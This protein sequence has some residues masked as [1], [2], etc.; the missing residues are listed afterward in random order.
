[1]TRNRTETDLR[2]IAL[3][4]K[5]PE[6]ILTPIKTP[7]ALPKAIV[8]LSR[9]SIEVAA[10]EVLAINNLDVPPMSAVACLRP[11]EDIK[12]YVLQPASGHS[13]DLR[14]F[15]AAAP[16]MDTMLEHAET[17]PEQYDPADIE[18]IRQAFL[19]AYTDRP[20]RRTRIAT[21]PIVN[22]PNL[23]GAL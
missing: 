12:G 4:D 14:G 10:R 1:M 20:H 3:Y 22:K 5:D 11:F 8:D 6:R 15:T 13:I 2:V 19:C 9:K 16:Y 18:F 7:N 23:T 21:R 17:H